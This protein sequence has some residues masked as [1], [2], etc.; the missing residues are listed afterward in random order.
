MVRIKICGLTRQCDIDAVNIEKP[1]Y[2]GFVFAESRRKVSAQLAAKLREK[3]NEDI[4]P[5]GVFVNEAAENILSLIKDGVIDAVQLHGAED[6]EYINRLKDSTEKPV[7][8]AVSVCKT[9]DIQKW[10]TTRADYLL[11]DHAGGGTG[12]PFDWDLIGETDK[13]YFLAGGLNADNVSDAVNQ[14]KPFAVD[15]SSGVETDGLKDS[16]KINAFIRNIAARN[17]H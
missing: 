13:P 3:L 2:I 1:D 16:K 8:K 10:A 6:E 5:V 15:V 7:I 14:L 12:H 4:T 11:L 17:T 9:G